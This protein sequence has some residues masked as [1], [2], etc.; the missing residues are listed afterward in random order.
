M[1][2]SIQILSDEMINLKEQIDIAWAAGFVD[3][4][5]CLH[6]GKQKYD[7]GRK[8]YYRLRLHVSQ[9]NYEVLAK[10]KATLAIH[11]NI[12]AI[13]RTHETN[14]QVY[15]LNYDGKHAYKAI[16]KLRPYL[17]R[18]RF[19]A[20]AAHDFWVE[21]KLEQKTGRKPVKVELMEIRERGYKKL[22]KLK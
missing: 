15:T 2:D 3:G 12:I 18:K 1:N 4:E 21:G 7:H 14:K 5:G 9:N 22:Q 13:K 8:V 20:D 16:M 10:L 19:E 17:V 6:I 11:A